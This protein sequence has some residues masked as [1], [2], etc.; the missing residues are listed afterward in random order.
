MKKA[1]ILTAVLLSCL[2]LPLTSQEL[3][4]E[5]SHHA[6]YFEAGGHGVLY[7]INYDYRF[8]KIFAARIG[9]THYTIPNFFFS[10]LT[11]T[12]F[13]I[14][15]EFLIGGDEHFFEIGAGIMPT[16]GESSFHFFSSSTSSVVGVANIGYRYQPVDEGF[17]FRASVPAFIT[18]TGVGGWGGLSFGYAF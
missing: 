8:A 7:T 16:I 9:F 1:A 17:F 3:T 6:L 2:N 4:P 14:I 15:G 13:P 11:I 10:D 5:Y 12:A 18:S